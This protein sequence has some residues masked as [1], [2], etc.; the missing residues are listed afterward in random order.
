MGICLRRHYNW[1]VAT[2]TRLDYPDHPSSGGICDVCILDGICEIGL[3]AKT[4]STTFPQ[5][6]GVAQFG[7]EK[8]LPNLDDIQILPEIFGEKILF[9]NVKAAT[10]LGGFKTTMPVIVGAMGSTKVAHSRGEI[11]A[12]GAA[13]AGLIMAIG[14]NILSTYG[15]K[16]LKERI[17]P[18]LDEYK[19]EGA[20]LVQGNVEDRKLGVF[21]KGIELG[22]HGIEIK[23]GQGAKMGL[24]GEIFFDCKEAE[25]YRKLGYT[26]V[27]EKEGVCE[28]H[29]SPGSIKKNEIKEMLIKYSDLKVP[30]WIKIA[31]GNGIIELLEFLN[32]LKKKE[33]IRLE[34]VV[35]DGYG[36]GTG[37]SPWQIMNEFSLPSACILSYFKKLRFDLI[38]TGGYTDGIDVAKAMMMGADGVAMGRAFLI[39][40]NLI[41]FVELDEKQKK[42]PKE[43]GII[44]FAEALKEELQMVCAIQRV[45]DVNE[46]KNRRENL[47]ALSGSA[48]SLFELKQKLKNKK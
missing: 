38:V 14:E 39:A 16:G 28:R 19:K 11:L 48:A 37:M 1:D 2:R 15:I 27:K 12:K 30:I 45:D 25:K 4:G 5:P 8:K 40:S 17:Q 44:N 31:V 20:V 6:F 41:N 47:V 24:G 46:L 18:F 13:K 43:Q 10:E 21:E 36:G 7:A 3:K 35:V 26:I 22:A 42:L 23:L 34:A 9:K 32:D 29:S 33:K